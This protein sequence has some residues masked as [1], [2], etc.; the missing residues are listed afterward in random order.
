M[1]QIKSA[2][3]RVVQT[4][5]RTARNR[6]HRERLR[7]ALKAFRAALAK[8]G[9]GPAAPEALGRVHKALDKAGTKGVLHRN[10]VNRRKS[11]MAAAAAKAAGAR[12]S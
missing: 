1:P 7:K 10:A 4:A 6:A 5:R 11:R 9:T 12:A 3:K 2:Q 8:P